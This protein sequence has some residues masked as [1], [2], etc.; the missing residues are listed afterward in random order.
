MTQRIRCIATSKLSTHEQKADL[1]LRRATAVA[2]Q[3]GERELIPPC[4]RG[5]SPGRSYMVTV[6][7]RMRWD[8]P[9]PTMTTHCTTLGTGRFGHPVQHRAIS[10][11]EAARFQSFPTATSSASPKMLA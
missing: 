4:Y 2:Q 8:D 6:Y 1:Q 9:A 11:R 7:G 10:L 5:R 3:A